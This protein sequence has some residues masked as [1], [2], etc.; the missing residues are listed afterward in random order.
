MS[1][2]PTPV[3][4]STVHARRFTSRQTWRGSDRW[5]DFVFIVALFGASALGNIAAYNG[6]FM[7]TF[8]QSYDPRQWSIGLI[9]LLLG[10]G[11]QLLCQWRQYANSAPT[12]IGRLRN[13]HYVIALLISAA[14]SLWVFGPVLTATLGF[15]LGT[16]L[17]VFV[18]FGVDIIQ[19]ELL[20]RN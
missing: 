5:M 19:E 8:N 12:L 1:N 16:L 20:F 18:V 15:P 17:A 11:Q 9:P 13:R 3:T 4:G 2:V 14:P 10:L 7:A 6:G